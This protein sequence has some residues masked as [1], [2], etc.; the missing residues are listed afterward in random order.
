M[1]RRNRVRWCVIIVYDGASGL[2]HPLVCI[3]RHNGLSADSWIP[4]MDWFLVNGRV[5]HQCEW[6]WARLWGNLLAK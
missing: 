6:W 3:G 2:R 5:I 1:Y 4:N